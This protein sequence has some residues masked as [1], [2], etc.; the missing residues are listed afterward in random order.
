MEGSGIR[1][2]CRN[3]FKKLKILSLASQYILSLMFVVQ[4][5]N[6]FQQT[7]KKTIETLDKE[8]IYTFLKQT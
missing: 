8:I 4:N 6:F 3:L 7:K 2:L 5:K 1:V